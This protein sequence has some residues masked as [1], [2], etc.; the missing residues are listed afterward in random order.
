LFFPAGVAADRS[1]NVYIADS[2]SHEVRKVLP[3]GTITRFAGTGRA[4][5]A[6]RL[7]GDGRLAT[8]ARL[9]IPFGVAVAGSG[10]GYIT[11]LDL[12]DVRGVSMSGTIARVAGDGGQCASPPRCHDGAPA[13]RAELSEPEGI[14]VDAA[15]NVYIADSG[16]QEVRE[17]RAP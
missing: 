15:M 10:S 9:A 12:G 1:G 11:D 5:L 16:D 17:V 7:C 14:A 3:D 13:T 4:C 6:V 8:S 2:D